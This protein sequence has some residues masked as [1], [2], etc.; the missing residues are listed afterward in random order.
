MYWES[1]GPNRFKMN[2]IISFSGKYIYTDDITSEKRMAINTKN[3]DDLL[4][5]IIIIFTSIF[6]SYQTILIGPIYAYLHDGLRIN[7]LGTHLPFFELNSDA[8]FNANMSIDVL[9]GVFTMV[10][11]YVIELVS[12]IVN[13]TISAMPDIIHVGLDEFFD[14]FKQ[15]GVHLK[16]IAQLRNVH[17]QIQD[18]N[19]Y[20]L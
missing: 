6:F 7:A 5:K 19:E 20:E 10:G 18:F 4:R 16:S 1:V 17:L 2:N 11:S 15:N 3:V 8:D 14:E 9:I 13:N 12:A